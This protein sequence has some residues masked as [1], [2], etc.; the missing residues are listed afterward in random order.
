MGLVVA[1]FAAASGAAGQ[2][3]SPAASPA[4]R[5][6]ALATGWQPGGYFPPPPGDWPVQELTP[7]LSAVDPEQLRRWHELL[8]SEPHVAGTPGDQ[9]QAARI[10]EAMAELGLAVEKHEVWVYLSKPAGA[11]LEIVEGTDGGSRRPL[12]IKE[13]I[14][15]EDIDSSNPDLTWGWN[16][17]SGTGDVTAPIVYANQ[18]TVADFAKLKEL[19]VSVQ[20]KIVLCRYGGNFRGYKVKY[21][22]AAGAVGV[23]IFTD[24]GDGAVPTYP[25]GGA[26]N[27]SCIERGSILTLDYPGDPLTPGVEATRDAKRLDAETVALPRIPVQ[28][29]GWGAAREI[30][31]RMAASNE[32]HRPAGADAGV[33]AGA[34]ATASPPPLPEGWQSRIAVPH[35][36]TGGPDL[37]LR[38]KVE[39][40]RELVATWNIVGT[41]KGRT[42][43]DEWIIVGSHHDAWGFGAC[44]PAAGTICTMEA[45][46]VFAAAARAGQPP[47]RTMKFCAW[48]AEEFGIIGSTEWVESRREELARS[49]L[50]Y[51]NLDMSAMGA[52][53]GSAAAPALKG[54]IAQVAHHV[55]AVGSE[56][57]SDGRVIGPSVFDSWIT[58]EP[59]PQLPGHPK[60]GDLG[61]GSDHVAF[62]CHAGVASASMGSS[63]S[64]GSAYHSVYDTL[65]WYRQN[66]G[67][68]YQASRMVTQMV[69]GTMAMIDRAGWAVLDP[70]RSLHDAASRLAALSNQHST[71]LGAERVAAMREVEAIS[72]RLAVQL[73]RTWPEGQASTDFVRREMWLQAEGLPQRPWFRNALAAPDATSGYASWVLPE[74]T[75]A[76]EA[77][78]HAAIDASIGALRARLDAVSQQLKQPEPESPESIP[79][80]QGK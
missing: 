20:G 3:K 24:G 50:A 69:V 53:F 66:V 57:S 37:K 76:I 35:Q 71:V 45:A 11:A 26:P 17:Y 43:P 80:Q 52:Q 73:N 12:V 55:P 44:D 39:Q 51:I 22:Q 36:L 1:G 48:G 18:G 25:A 58:R 47:N 14:V 23:V 64:P 42:H 62:W 78:D 74:I 77:G 59:D 30:L 10:A 21:A 70:A 2:N 40:T 33:A 13:T 65:R 41:L 34:T 5:T 38:L 63:G 29:I 15:A 19:G 79:P 72:R 27:D 8:A 7:R 28:P 31:I 6:V 32:A 75:G 68:D 56:L 4:G 46:R 67:E 16:A 49:G 61:G 54:V 60:F 9:R